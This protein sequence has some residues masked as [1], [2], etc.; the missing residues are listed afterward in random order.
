MMVK[1]MVINACGQSGERQMPVATVV[2]DPGN[3]S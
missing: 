3:I 2:E 1:L